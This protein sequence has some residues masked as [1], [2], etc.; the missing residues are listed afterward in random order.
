MRRSEN[1]KVIESLRNEIISCQEKEKINKE[2]MNK[3]EIEI[4]TLKLSVNGIIIT[5]SSTT[6]L[7]IATY[8][9]SIIN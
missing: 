3:Q 4:N 5:T 2:I 6:I 7:C 8:L 9:F 1:G